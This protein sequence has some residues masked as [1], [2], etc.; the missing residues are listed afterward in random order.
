[1][2][3][4]FLSCTALLF[5]PCQHVTSS[6]PYPPIVVLRSVNIWFCLCHIHHCCFKIWSTC[7]VVCAICTI[8][9][10]RSVNMWFCLCHINHC[11]FEIIMSTY[12]SVCAI[13]TIVVSFLCQH[14]ILSLPYQTLLFSDLSTC[15]FVC[16]ICTIIV[17]RSVNMQ[18]CLCHIR[19]CC[20][21]IHIPRG[22]INSISNFE[23]S[24]PQLPLYSP[25]LCF[26]LIPF[27][28]VA[29]FLSIFCLIFRKT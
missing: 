14:V 7:D 10:F 9:V 20:L 6:V 19:H 27:L 11:C 24:V 25:S 15:D 29:S 13:L 1:M 17:F 26:C 12:D 18:F 22:G 8:I 4:V 16:A 21:D 2:V 3:I 28:S 5:P 23:K